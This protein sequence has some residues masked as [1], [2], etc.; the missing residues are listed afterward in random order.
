MTRQF[1]EQMQQWQ[2]QLLDLSKT[3]PLLNHHPKV[4]ITKLDMNA[5][6]QALVEKSETLTFKID[7]DN[8]SL[9]ADNLS[10]QELYK[11]LVKLIKKAKLIQEEKGIHALYLSF[12]ALQW[13]EGDMTYQS[14]L[15]LVPVSL[16]KPA[17]SSVF[18]LKRHSGEVVLNPT[19]VYKMKS[20]F[21]M[22]LP[23]MA[24]NE[25]LE[26][27]FT[28][29]CSLFQN[30]NWQMLRQ[31]SLSIL[32]FQKMN[33][34][35]DLLKYEKQF[36]AHPIIRLLTGKPTAL[37]QSYG[38]NLND[39]Q[40]DPREVYQ[41]LDADASQQEAIFA[42]KQSKSFELIGPPGTGKSQTIVNII[43]ENLAMGKKVLFV[44]QKAAALEVVYHRLQE[45]ALDD[46]CLYLSSPDVSSQHIVQQLEHN[47]CLAEQPSEV[48]TNHQDFYMALI[49]RRNALN[50]HAAALHKVIEPL[51]KRIYDVYGEL[52]LYTKAPDLIF[53]IPRIQTITKEELA[54]R[55]SL[56]KQYAHV[57]EKIKLADTKPWYNTTL[58]KL[59][60]EVRQEMHAALY[61]LDQICDRTRSFDE[62][63]EISYTP[64]YLGLR[65][66]NQLLALA[67]SSPLVPAHWLDQDLYLYKELTLTLAEKQDLYNQHFKAIEE[68]SEIQLPDKRLM[69]LSD[70]EHIEENLH[71][72][73]KQTETQYDLPQSPDLLYLQRL[74]QFVLGRLEEIQEIYQEVTA[75]YDK[76]IFDLEAKELLSY[77]RMI[78]QSPL[79][80]LRQDYKNH[81]LTILGLQKNY[82]G[83]LSDQKMMALLEKVLK[84]QSIENELKQCQETMRTAFGELYQ[85]KDTD[86][87]LF[88]KEMQAYFHHLEILGHLYQ[89][90]SYLEMI[91]EKE[92]SLKQAFDFMYDGHTTNWQDIMKALDWT[93]AFQKALTECPQSADW[94]ASVC[95]DPAAIVQVMKQSLELN[96]LLDDLASLMQWYIRLFPEGKSYL[97]IGLPDMYEQ[98]HL[99]LS[100]ES[101]LEEWLDICELQRACQRAGLG[102]YLALVQN[103][104]LVSEQIIPAYLKRFYHLWLDAVH[105]ELVQFR[106]EKQ[107]IL[108]EEFKEMDTRQIVLARKALRQKLIAQIQN[109]HYLSQEAY[110][111]NAIHPQKKMTSVRTLFQ[112]MPDLLVTLKPCLM[113]SPSAVSQLLEASQFQFDLVIFD[114]ASQM[115][116]EDALGAILRAKQVIIAGDAKQ[117]PPTDFFKNQDSQDG[118]THA[119]LDDASVLPKYQLRWH[120]RSRQEDLI[121]FSNEH[122]YHQQLQTFPSSQISGPDQGVEYIYV[123]DGYYDKGGRKGNVQEAQKVVALIFEHFQKHP[124]R[125]LGVVAFGTNQQAAIEDELYRQRKENPEYEQFFND[126]FFIKNLENV[127]G[128]E[129]DTMILSIGYGKDSAGKVYLNFGPLNQAGGIYRL[130]VAITRAKYNMKVVGSLLPEEI[131]SENIGVKMLSEFIAYARK[132]HHSENIGQPHFD[133]PFEASVYQYLSEH[134]YTPV[135][136]VGCSGYKIDMAIPSPQDPTQYLLGIECDGAS[137]HSSQ[138]ARERDRLRQSVLENMGWKIYRIW[139]TEWFRNSDKEGQRLIDMIEKLIQQQR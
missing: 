114:E 50:Q 9:T 3:N 41:V 112:E 84:V 40:I 38:G 107:D 72:K 15:L 8:M 124:E 97:D 44:S 100:Q 25:N 45:A 19:L 6:W 73:I 91:D 39:S 66:L 85:S 68:M 93:T 80:Y 116:T 131:Q 60:N 53:N 129:R 104:Q 130:N 14:P 65:A 134:G 81:R 128:D 59:S 61:T 123:E 4:L 89:L 43:A 99:C 88:K 105:P 74:Y 121:A 126:T 57:A 30:N 64:S 117:L 36:Y 70:I 56:L 106:K 77:F 24:I 58:T 35:E 87:T 28:K 31:C 120:Y 136:Q 49:K 2:N 119:L 109:N 46:F 137:Y 26:V 135:T 47:L 113:M 62:T 11:E 10:W 138:T 51:H 55:V 37:H 34:Y 20:G 110:L 95:R 23:N 79:K 86:L 29:L 108:V 67:A 22:D 90:R 1:T 33:M 16:S 83:K 96:E 32:S 82:T 7:Q 125:S 115:N 69:T 98:M 48:Q 132:A 21:D 13:Q 52:S 18:K 102:D 127:Q 76:E 118:F 101:D 27:Y 42:S 63:S 94:T 17:L 54:T 5:L 139:S 92:E 75:N 122:I 78:Y 71:L 103:K 111:K 12:G 133:S